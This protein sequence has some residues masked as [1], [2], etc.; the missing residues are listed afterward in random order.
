MR[1]S[2]LHLEGGHQHIASL[3]SGQ[4]TLQ[5]AMSYVQNKL[6]ADDW[7]EFPVLCAAPTSQRAQTS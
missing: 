3:L 4:P 1:A 6:D 7:V 2:L 5:G